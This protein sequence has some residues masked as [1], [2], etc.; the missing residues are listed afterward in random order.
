MEL[1]VWSIIENELWGE[2]FEPLNSIVVFAN[3]S[4]DKEL[5]TIVW[6]NGADFAPEFLYQ[7]LRPNYALQKIVLG[8]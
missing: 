4:F 8:L 5:E 1:K 3:F 7:Q 6:S 2:V